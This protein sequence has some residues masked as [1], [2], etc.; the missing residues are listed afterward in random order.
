MRVGDTSDA[1]EGFPPGWISTSGYSGVT[2]THIIPVA[3]GVMIEK[4]EIYGH[5]L[6]CAFLAEVEAVKRAIEK[7]LRGITR[8]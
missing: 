2:L 5:H 7:L 3:H 6:H 8:R 1:S 4:L